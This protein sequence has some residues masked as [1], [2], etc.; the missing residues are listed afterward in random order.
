MFAT[1]ATRHT[2]V[3][4][5]KGTPSRHAPWQRYPAQ[6]ALGKSAGWLIAAAILL[7][8]VALA[9]L[10][11]HKTQ[12][13]VEQ[14]FLY[15]AEQ[16]R[17]K[18]LF[19]MSAHAQVLR[20]ATA[21]FAA[22]N[23]V[24]R[25]EWRDYVTKL[26]LDK[27]LPGIQGTGFTRMIDRRD[28]AAHERAIRAEGFTDYAITP[29]GERA[30]Y[31]SIVYIEPFTGR[32]LK[33]FG[34]DMFAEPVRGLAMARAR[35]SGEPALTGR[36]TLVQEDEQNAQPGFLMYV[37]IYRKD[38][39]TASVEQ[40]RAA[41]LG[42]TYSPFRAHDLLSSLF[43]AD[44]KDVELELFDTV[45]TPDNLL[46]DSHPGD[47][48]AHGQYHVEMPLDFGGQRWIA[49]FHSRPEF[50]RIT[51][52]PLPAGI[53]LA[54]AL[55]ALI[56]LLWH[57]RSQHHQRDI[58]AYAEQLQN[59]EAQLRT[60]I[61]TMPDAV[62]LKDGEGRLIEANTVFLRL[63]GLDDVDYRGKTCREL[64]RS[65]QF[66]DSTLAGL[67]RSDETAWAHGSHLHDEVVIRL[68]DRRERVFE[69]AKV[70][71]FTPSGAR[72][73]LV[74]VGHEITRR[75]Q[76]E[77]ELQR[78]RDHLEETVAARTADLQLAKEAAEAANRAK[79]TFLANM[80]HELRTPMN[81]IIG[82][83]HLLTLRAREAAE[84]D[85]LGKVSHAAN[86]LLG[87][88]NNILDLSK[89][90]ADHLSLEQIPLKLDELIGSVDTL[91]SERIHAKGL[92]LHI[93]ISP[94]LG[95]VTLL[96]DPLRIKQIL[97]NLFDNALKF[98]ERGSITLRAGVLTETADDLSFSIAITD[99]GKGI[100]AEAQERIFS[101]FEQ[102]DG[103]TTREHGGT[104]L[105]LAIVRQLSRLMHGDI[106][107]SST[108]GQG[109]TFT[110]TACLA[111]TAARPAPEEA[112]SPAAPVR[113]ARKRLLLAED[114]EINREVA[115]ELLGDYPELSI[116]VAENGALAVERASAGRYDLVLMDIEMPVLD[117]IAATRAIRQLP[118]HAATPIVAMTANAFAE[119][120]A[121]CLDAGMSDFIAKPVDP[122]LL[123]A[124]LDRWLNGQESA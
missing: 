3:E 116:D 32:N 2:P 82:L 85:K 81:A 101:P 68:A 79:T 13:Q 64:T 22:S 67:E 84:R 24:S 88:L 42:F 102:A 54:G 98:T 36:V 114:D 78:H 10:V 33:A 100:P 23:E 26:Q 117:G 38:Q 66:A 8:S 49:R 108:P 124:M 56:A 61:N 21:L 111:K 50:D 105:G 57:L 74:T 63:C 59:S 27:T 83:T 53:G 121:R 69:L 25:A 12:Q 45:A 7:A 43:S 65:G 37:P 11:H 39:P 91:V 107:V 94:R 118:G 73:A 80:S 93:D 62:C 58:A 4:N 29:P 35:D 20:G 48:R 104:G 122:D 120:K 14:R 9:G 51:A 17:S 55:L 6:A 40:R 106:T 86:H 34:Y 18:I 1:H 96:G 47:N 19:R 123:F 46:F 72:Q 112:T 103:S 71:L 92:A 76:N 75:K 5:S 44:N 119:D 115:L 90:E 77:A 31:S 87:L 41:L 52:S 99:T 109:S 30:Q 28:K 16:E 70:A 89:I 60:L 95:E 97:I 15:R 110:L 113:T